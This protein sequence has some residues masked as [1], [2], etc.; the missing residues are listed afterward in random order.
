MGSEFWL[1]CLVA[2]T[3]V[4]ISHTLNQDLHVDTL[5]FL[6]NYHCYSLCSLVNSIHEL[7]SG[8]SQ[9]K[10]EFRIMLFWLNHF[11]SFLD[12]PFS[13]PKSPFSCTFPLLCLRAQSQSGS[14]L[15]NPLDCSPP[16]S[17]VHGVLQSG[18]LEFVVIFSSRGSS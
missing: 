2:E 9:F 10:S 1:S 18:I 15:Y 13:V 14:T 16:G 5:S 8:K 3:S 6:P 11:K 4:C 17:S 7:H 12:F